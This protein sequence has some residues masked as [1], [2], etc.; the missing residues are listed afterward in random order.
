MQST[1]VLQNFDLTMT[2]LSS[3]LLNLSGYVP[4]WQKDVAYESGEIVRSTL[5]DHQKYMCNENEHT[6][7]K[8]SDIAPMLIQD[9]TSQLS[10]EE[11]QRQVWVP[12]TSLEGSLQSNKEASLTQDQQLGQ[13]VNKTENYEE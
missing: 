9:F 8:C 10:E 5:F 12:L 4:I 6:D 1:A 3:H 2:S 13:A 7:L 11:L